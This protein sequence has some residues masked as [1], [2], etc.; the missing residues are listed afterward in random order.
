MLMLFAVTHSAFA[1]CDSPAAL[2]PVPPQT[3]TAFVLKWP[4]VPG[5]TQYQLRYWESAKPDDK[6]IVDDCGSVPFT[7]RGLRKNTPYTLQIRSKCGSA[8]SGWGISLN[9][10]TINSSGTCNNAPSGVLVSGGSSDISVTWTSTGSHTI[11]YRLGTTGEW[12]IPPGALNAANASFTIAGLSPGQYQVEIKRN[13]SATASDYQ[14]HLLTLGDAC[15]TPAAP[16]VSPDQT[17]ALVDLPLV[18]GV[19]G[20]HLDYRIGSSGAW[21]SAGSNIP[22]SSYLLNPPLVPSTQYQVQI[23]A[24]CTLDTSVFSPVVTFTTGQ[25]IGPCLANKN[26]GKDLSSQAILELNHELNAPSAFSFASM[27]GLNDGGL[28]FRSF[29][30]ESSNQITLLTTQFRNFHTMDEDFDNSLESYDLNIKP[31]DT[32]PEGTPANMW[33]N[34]SLYTL[35]RQTHGFANITSATE[36]LQYGPQSWKEKIYR[37]S[38]WS[39]SGPAGIKNSFTNYTKKFIDEFAPANGTGTQILVS[40]FQVGNELWDYPVKADYHSLLQGAHSAFVLK[41]GLKSDGGWKMKLVAGAFQAYRDNNCSSILRDFSNCNGAL[42]RHD[43]IGDYL[44]V[45]DCDLLKDLDALDC[46]PYSFLPG[47]TNWTHPESPSS[48]SWQIRNMAAWLNA[49]KNSAT[50]VL[51]KTRLWSTEYGFDSNPTSGVGE[52]TQSAYLVR[53]LFLHSRYHFEKVFF[54]NAFDVARPTD[55]YYNGLYNSAGFWRLGTHPAN[56]AWASPIE[57]HGA[58]AKPVWFAMMDLKERFG[59]HVFHKVLVED[60]DA[61]VILIAKPDSTEPYLVFW[62]PRQTN[63]ANIDQDIPFAIT[64]NWLGAF[65]EGYTVD[66]NMAQSFAQ[67]VQSG[68]AFEALTEPMCGSVKLDIIRRNPAFVRLV[69]CDACSNITHP[70]SIVL[71]I[72]NM[73]SAPFDPGLISSSAEA[74]GG[75]D[76]TIEYQWQQSTDNIVFTNIF[77]ATAPDY[78]PPSISQTTY[79][80]RAAKR[81]LCRDYVHGSSVAIVVGNACPKIRTF[82]R[83]AHDMQGCSPNGDYFYEMVLDNVAMNEQIALNGLPLNGINIPLCML[84]GVALTTTTF[85]AN[86]HFVASNALQWQVNAGAGSTQTLRLYYCWADAY[87]NPVELTTATSLCSGLTTPCAEGSNLTDPGS[88]ERDDSF[89]SHS[90]ERF[91]FTTTPNPS[92]E[93]LLLTYTGAPA[94]QSILRILTTNGQCVSTQF[95]AALEDRQ[96]WEVDTHDIPSGIYFVCLQTGTAVQWVLWERI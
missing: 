26:A 22:P 37:E 4:T 20:Y 78:N 36:L 16:T 6:T 41:Y 68:Q 71:P 48:E 87:P 65:A 8:I 81:S 94:A 63:D 1:Q 58:T 15:T 67:S 66:G 84:N 89:S 92:T 86:L 52:K 72:P 46:H 32:N 76:G 44:E 49:N 19:T 14:R 83:V 38:D 70:G 3:S 79:F 24:I 80:R 77:G 2:L 25:Q 47:T 12:L 56:S 96:Q 27:I 10:A 42:E 18:N 29:Q 21:I 54:Y 39:Q 31:K 23:Q 95:I 33:Y 28:V 59:E 60:A 93:Q 57:A 13:C 69:N 30:N 62:S 17:S 85:L 43:F 82:Q 88:G 90:E 51:D 35:Y 73:G 61:Y 64:I 5:A 55:T 45:A 11:R 53:G 50:G 34:K 40:N 91:H 7:L 74:S 75:S 9:I